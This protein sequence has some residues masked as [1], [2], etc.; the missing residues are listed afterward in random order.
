MTNEE[1]ISRLL[2]FVRYERGAL[3]VLVENDQWVSVNNWQSH[4]PLFSSYRLNN[5]NNSEQVIQLQNYFY[6][7]FYIPGSWDLNPDLNSAAIPEFSL[8]DIGQQKRPELVDEAVFQKLLRNGD[9]IVERGTSRFILKPGDYVR[10]KGTEEAVRIFNHEP[11]TD[12]PI[13]ENIWFLSGSIQPGFDF[14]NQYIRFYLNVYPSEAAAVAHQIINYFDAY[15]VPFQLKYLSPELFINRCDRIVLYVP[16]RQFTVASFLILH[17]YNVCES[18]FRDGLPLFSKPLLPGLGF[19]EDPF[20]AESFGKSRCGWIACAVANWVADLDK[21]S[22]ENAPVAMLLADI[23][24]QQKIENLNRMHLNPDSIYPYDFNIFN[25]S[26]SRKTEFSA[27]DSWLQ[28][29]VEIAHFLCREAVWIS[30]EQCTWLGAVKNPD[31]E[32]VY[33]RLNEEWER[34]II[35]TVLFLHSVKKYINDPLYQYIIERSL[36]DLESVLSTSKRELNTAL[37]N[38]YHYHP[39]REIIH[40]KSVNGQNKSCKNTRD[41]YEYL[42]SEL[43]NVGAEPGNRSEQF[44]NILEHIRQNACAFT[45]N[46]LGS[47]HFIPGINGLAL[48][49]FSYLAAHDRWFPPV[50]FVNP[51]MGF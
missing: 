44:Y 22:S 27:S 5:V 19:A 49:G 13:N 38:I 43:K 50:P 4:T 29:A 8:T 48:V 40:V 25:L 2:T 20:V 46:E 51:D 16:Q 24:I 21:K 17:V 35:G 7:T 33:R 42:L 12:Q 32:I 9:V 10:S 3:Q 45:I 14:E 30:P 39:L 37:I 1:I 34:G 23:K 6:Y 36:P 18:A 11:R 47:N 41:N 15:E 26:F 28:G 31:N